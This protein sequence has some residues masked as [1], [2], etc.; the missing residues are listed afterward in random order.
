[1]GP[2]IAQPISDMI[3]DSIW[4]RALRTANRARL[5]FSAEWNPSTEISPTWDEA[6]ELMIAGLPKK[7]VAEHVRHW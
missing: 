7:Q 1:M 3:L 6:I 2:R 5:P 4:H